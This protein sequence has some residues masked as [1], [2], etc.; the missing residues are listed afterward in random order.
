ME[1]SGVA[2]IAT[3]RTLCAVS[4]HWCPRLRRTIARTAH[5]PSAQELAAVSGMPH[6]L[7]T[8]ARL[9]SPVFL[10]ISQCSGHEFTMATASRYLYVIIQGTPVADLR[11][12]LLHTVLVVWV[13]EVE[14]RSST[15]FS[16]LN[17]PC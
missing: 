15:V 14:H 2:S 10:C 12:R 3:V 7:C 9:T 4:P 16:S 17:P 11:L 6:G 8:T 5:S 13:H 1:P